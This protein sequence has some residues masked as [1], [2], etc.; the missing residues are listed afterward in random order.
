[1]AKSFARMLG[2]FLIASALYLNAADVLLGSR[3][4][5]K[6]AVYDNPDLSLEVKL[7]EA[8][9]IN[10]P[11]LGEVGVGGLT[12]AAASSKL[13]KLLKDGQFVR[14]PQVSI[15][16][17]TSHSQ[18]ASV[19]GEVKNPGLYP[20]DG[21][22]TITDVLAMAGG[23]TVEGGDTATLVRTVDG[24]TTKDIID[25]TG[26]AHFGD[27]EKNKVLVTGDMV[28]VDRFLK[29]YIYGEV[30]KPGAYRLERD[31]TVL[32]VLSVGGGLTPRGTSRGIRLKR[33][34]A[35]GGTTE[36]AVKLE[37]LVRPD[38]ILY[39]RESLF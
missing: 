17:L 24:K 6:I 18:M 23:V 4:I 20:V 16:V 38:D 8:G 25:I 15:T 9:I 13:A 22:L 37:D 19:L 3:D 26:M 5:I 14:D 21:K 32:Q 39:V 10:F 11:L 12:P 34:D 27:T 2:A 35:T 7:N 30:N 33:R 29:V 31:M 28:F 1:M 36:A